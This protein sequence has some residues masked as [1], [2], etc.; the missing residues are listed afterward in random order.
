MDE[1]GCGGGLDS[2]QAQVQRASEQVVI[3]VD[4]RVAVVAAAA[5]TTGAAGIGR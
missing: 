4:V 5:T 3:S 1:S 2:A